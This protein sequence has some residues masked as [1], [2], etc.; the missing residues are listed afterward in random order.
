MK[1]SSDPQILSQTK[2]F[3]PMKKHVFLFEFCFSKTYAPSARST[4]QKRK[5]GLKC[6]EN[7]HA[8]QEPA[9]KKPRRAEGHCFA[10]LLA[11]PVLFA[12]GFGNI[13]GPSL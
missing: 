11:L 13:F 7:R 1:E 4:T 3:E 2:I 9:A 12:A 8:K 6:P 5:S 10:S